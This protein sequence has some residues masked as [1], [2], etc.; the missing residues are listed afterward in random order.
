MAPTQQIEPSPFAYAMR[1]DHGPC[2]GRPPAGS[3]PTAVIITPTRSTP[4][5][6]LCSQGTWQLAHKLPVLLLSNSQRSV[7]IYYNVIARLLPTHTPQAHPS[8]RTSGPE[9]TP[10]AAPAAALPALIYK[11][12]VRIQS[13]KQQQQRQALSLCLFCC[14]YFHTL[15]DQRLHYAD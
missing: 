9:Q 12:H 14:F 3:D 4:H 6:A 1:A 13:T 8:G 10:Q 11:P 7:H 2:Q 5:Q 15:H